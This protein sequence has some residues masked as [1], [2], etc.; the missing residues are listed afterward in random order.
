VHTN[1]P[2]NRKRAYIQDLFESG[3]ANLQPSD[4]IL[5]GKSYSNRVPSGASYSKNNGPIPRRNTLVSER[6]LAVRPAA[7]PASRM[8]GKLIS[9]AKGRIILGAPTG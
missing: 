7:P 3:I 5:D 4:L 6:R 9:S 1:K 8:G 2:T